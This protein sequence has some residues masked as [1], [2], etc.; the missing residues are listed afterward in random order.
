[1]QKSDQPSKDIFNSEVSEES[2]S[3]NPPKLMR[4]VTYKEWQAKSGHGHSVFISPKPNQHPKSN[5]N[6]SRQN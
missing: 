6:E 4:L 2:K 5:E 1:M 3:K